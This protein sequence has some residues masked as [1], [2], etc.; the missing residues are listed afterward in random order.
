MGK[1]I[2]VAAETYRGSTVGAL[3]CSRRGKSFLAIKEKEQVGEG[4]G[5]VTWMAEGTDL[6][7][8]PLWEHLQ[9]SCKFFN[10]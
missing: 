8:S 6:Q 4:T 2:A 3:L 7:L 9:F 1:P 5:G 10:L